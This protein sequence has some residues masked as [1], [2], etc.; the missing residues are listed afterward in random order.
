MPGTATIEHVTDDDVARAEREAREAATLVETLRD[1]V[2]DGAA[3]ITAAD[4]TAA[5]ELADFAELRAESTARKAAATKEAARLAQLQQIA[6]EVSEYNTDG[7]QAVQ[8]LQAVEAALNAFADHCADRD[9]F[10]TE[11]MRKLHDL[12]VPVD[13]GMPGNRA[14]HAGLTWAYNRMI[15]A[16]GKRITPLDAGIFIG[17]AVAKVAQAKRLTA[18]G[19]PL[20][21]M[22]NGITDPCAELARRVTS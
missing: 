21:S 17:A 11:T 16:N 20:D 18:G 3:D 8:L 15:A 12:G 5:K 10:I 1:R 6:D 19:R 7:E 14:A 2:R 22:S 9:T 4:I 13:D